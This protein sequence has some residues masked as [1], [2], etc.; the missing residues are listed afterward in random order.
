MA[1]IN[2]SSSI[3]LQLFGNEEKL[4]CLYLGFWGQRIQWI[5]FHGDMGL[6]NE[7]FKMADKMAT[8][9]LSNFILL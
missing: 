8:T 7:K 9:D 6:L 5:S 3:S 4:W 2:I 1:A